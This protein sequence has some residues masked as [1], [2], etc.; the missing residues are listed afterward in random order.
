M[1]R[2]KRVFIDVGHGGTD[3]G[4]IG[5]GKKE[6]E[7][8]L[9]LAKEVKKYIGKKASVK[10]SRATN[11]EYL[12]LNDRTY[13]AKQWKADVFVSIHNNASS[14]QYASGV[15][16]LV[17]SPTCEGKKLADK[18]LSRYIIAGRRP[19]RGIKVRRDLHV[20]RA[21]T[22]PA[23][24]VEN[25]FISCVTESEKWFFTKDGISVSAKNIANGVLDYLG[26]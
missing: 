19:I 5:N 15:E 22:M 13:A 9:R 10:L 16:I 14:N 3:P 11:K 21:T 4:A 26:L 23:V 7:Q 20:L 17:Y 12:S 25:A 2:T 18:I 1:R 6:S 8:N 24:L